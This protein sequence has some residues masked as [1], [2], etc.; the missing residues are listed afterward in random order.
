MAEILI[1]QNAVNNHIDNKK[2][3]WFWEALA[4]NLGNPYYKIVDIKYDKESLGNNFQSL[5][6]NYPTAYTIGKYMLENLPH[7]KIIYYVKNPDILYQDADMIIE[8]AKQWFNENYLQEKDI[9]RIKQGEFVFY[10]VKN[11]KKKI[12]GA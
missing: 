9:E 4:T 8:N 3:G 2:V 11:D 12:K 6:N 7:D 1:C 5:E 10:Q